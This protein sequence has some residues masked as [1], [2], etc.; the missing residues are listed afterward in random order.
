MRNF[1]YLRKLTIG[2][3]FAVFVLLGTVLT[4]SAQ[5][6]ASEYKDWQR[7]QA[8]AEMRHQDYLRTGS[9]RDYNQWQ[10][11]MRRA[12]EQYLQYQQAVNRTGYNGYNRVVYNP[13]YYNSGY[14]T[15]NNRYSN[16]G[17]YRI[18]MNGA[19]YTVDY[20]GV[21]LLRQAVR[22]GY[23]QGFREGQR[24]RL[25]GRGYDM[26]DNDMYLSGTYGYPGYVDESQYQYYFQQGFQRGYDDG[27]YSRNQYGNAATILGN[28]LSTI[29]NIA[30]Q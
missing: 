29:L 27:Y 21:E 14:Y 8:K 26:S 3:V 6:P 28:V 16:V 23:T 7:A 12:Q 2:S 24:D 9:I 22:T 1:K 25:S 4:A 5:N 19:Y 30:Q 13:G 10:R 15:T 17:A 18:Y 11:E 20:R